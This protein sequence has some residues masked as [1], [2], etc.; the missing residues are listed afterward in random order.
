MNHLQF[1]TSPYLLQ[2]A[3]NPVEWYAWK[4]EALARAKRENKPILVS[5]GY[6]TCH[7]CHVMERESFEDSDIA[8]YMNEHFINIK[9]DRE[10]RPDLDQIFMEACIAISGSG[11]WPLNCFLTPDGRPFYAGTYYPP[12]PAG[13]RPSWIQLLMH[14]AKIF[15]EER[16]KVE[17]QAK[18]LAKT[19]AGSG[20]V[21]FSDDLAPGQLDNLFV[22][23]LADELYEKMM[24]QAD[25]KHGGFGG[26]PKFPTVMSM[27]YLMVY[28]ELKDKPEGLEHVRFSLEKMI[29]GGIYDQL[30]GGFARYATDNAWLIPHFEKML[31]DNALLV[32]VLSDYLRYDSQPLFRMAIKE[33]L[34]FIEREMSHEG[35]GFYSALDADSE[36]IEGK[37]Y[38]WDYGEIYEV[39]DDDAQ[40][41]CRFYG[42][43]PSGNWE[44]TNILW[45]PHVL[46]DFAKAE[47]IKVEE[48]VSKL[49]SAKQKLFQE[50]ATKV[51]PGLDYKIL[52]AWN[53]L[54]CI[55]YAK[56][57]KA[58][59]EETYKARALKNM[60]FLEQNMK[61]ANGAWYRSGTYDAG[62]WKPQYEAFLEDYTYL[63]EAMLEVYELTFDTTWIGKAADL[64]DRII[65]DFFDSE[66]D[67]YYFTGNKQEDVPLR[68]IDIMDNAIPSGNAVLF[69]VFQRLAIL[70]GREDYQERAQKMG[71]QVLKGVSTYPGSF[72]RWAKGMLSLIKPVKEIAI[73][74]SEAMVFAQK[75]Q[76]LPL[77]NR[78]VMA[79]REEE[80]TFPLLANRPVRA[81][82]Q[83]YICEN[84]TCQRPVETIAAAAE[85]LGQ[86]IKY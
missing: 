63:A 37:F 51:R 46:E 36:G 10:E 58:T 85:L 2:H 21:F 78:V 17:I 14:M 68:R 62:V 81:A 57:Y 7:W 22:E 61:K 70:T 8:A 45:R 29:R 76:Q 16:D 54:M 38:V 12:R 86:A 26:A 19:A 15:R 23:E 3:N 30:G 79:T 48:L 52:L 34:A 66:S 77:L 35:G 13:N 82:T 56:A 18:K 59:A 42:V 80:Q 20:R 49:E 28:H 39:L 33:T 55:A 11:G 27:E 25:H 53:A 73:V 64:C 24:K 65:R 84:F 75:I 9:I 32:G 41:F 44:Y 4:P 72:A 31:Y 6:S 60:N 69:E 71:Q 50:R 74:G 47:G 83:I 67:L 5:V 1:E 43:S 40:W